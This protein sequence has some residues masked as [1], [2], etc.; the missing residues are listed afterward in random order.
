MSILDLDASTLAGYIRQGTVTSL[1]ATE[2]YIEHLK[3][4]NPSVNCLVEERFELAR[5][6]ARQCDDELAS[7]QN[8]KGRLYG[9]PISMKEAFDVAG[10]RT[11]GGLRHRKNLVMDHD[12]AIVELL[13]HEGAIILGKSNTPTLCFCQETDN[14]LYGRT[15]NPWDLS[16]TVGGSSGG[17]AALIAAGGAALGIGSDIGGSIR[18]PSHFNGIIGFKSGAYQVKDDGAYPPFPHPLQ[19]RMLGIGAIA[20]SVRDARLVNDILALAQPIKRN[21]SD[22]SITLPIDQ[23]KY[24]VSAQTM[25]LLKDLKL[26]L[27]E[28]IQ[29]VDEQPPMYEQSALLWQQI[30]SIDGASNVVNAA[31]GKR[32]LKPMRHWLQER[33]AGNSE[34]HRY[35]LWALVGARTFKPSK[36]QM[37]KLNEQI[38]L[39]N[40]LIQEYLQHKLL[41]LPV[42]HSPAL[43]HGQVYKEI[44]AISKSFLKYMPFVA[45]ANTW[46]LPSL[47]IPIGEENG[48]P[49]SIQIISSIGNEDAIFSLGEKIESRFRGWK[50]AIL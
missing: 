6:E 25:L 15:N 50:R 49:V 35:L 32:L 17:E 40:Q 29:V 4:I 26:E 43:P 36:Q 41:I 8:I 31:S 16:R 9:V 46:G 38:N 3:R 11:T 39:G 37:A 14:K 28:A 48:L 2:A 30:M 5:H 33:I 45:Y 20:K 7:N 1:E 10:M 19:E 23:V 34:W 12:A 47:V 22:F 27:E 21:L 18:F 42:Y 13:R 44:F 24:E